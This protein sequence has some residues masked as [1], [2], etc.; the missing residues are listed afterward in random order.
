MGATPRKSRRG[1]TDKIDWEFWSRVE[2]MQIHEFAALL[3]GT[4]PESLIAAATARIPAEEFF[5]REQESVFFRVERLARAALEAGT[6]Q[7]AWRFES[8]RRIWVDEHEVGSEGSGVVVS[9][10]TAK[11]VAWARGRRLTLPEALLH[12][13][14]PAGAARPPNEEVVEGWKDILKASGL[15]VSEKSLR[16]RLRTAGAVFEPLGKGDVVRIRRAEL[17]RVLGATET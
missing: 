17:L 11:L 12:W 10:P 2:V 5:T 13:E 6:L 9:L 7:G 8:G 1:L 4:A 14:A 3:A 15:A 16:Q